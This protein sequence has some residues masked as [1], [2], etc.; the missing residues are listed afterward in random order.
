MLA[1]RLGAVAVLG[2]AYRQPPAGK[3]RASLYACALPPRLKQPQARASAGQVVHTCTQ[4]AALA[5]L[6]STA[7]GGGSLTC[8]SAE[9]LYPPR[10]APLY[11]FLV[12]ADAYRYA[13]S[14]QRL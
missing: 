8:G 1:T 6:V 11:A 10:C 13:G 12:G 3:A 5:R 9:T 4:A 2:H 7:P 14:A